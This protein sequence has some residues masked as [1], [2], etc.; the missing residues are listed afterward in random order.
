[1]EAVAS[2]V[3]V[4]DA[5]FE[6]P[7]STSIIIEDCRGIEKSGKRVL[8]LSSYATTLLEVQGI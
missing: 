5:D 3:V 1:M 4:V 2:L 8:S 7:A 6:F